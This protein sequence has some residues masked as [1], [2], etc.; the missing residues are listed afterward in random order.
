MATKKPTPPPEMK[1]VGGKP[2]EGE[3]MMPTIGRIV[4]VHYR[5]GSY[6]PGKPEPAIVCAVSTS[7]LTLAGFDA[8]GDPF[9]ATLPFHGNPQVPCPA[10]AHACWPPLA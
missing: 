5:S 9:K 8:N 2:T 3:K 7:G 6:S 10:A 4:D 1:L